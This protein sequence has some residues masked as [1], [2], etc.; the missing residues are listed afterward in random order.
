[1]AMA[2]SIPLQVAP[3]AVARVAEL[4]MQQEFEAMLEHARQTVA[5]LRSLE[6]TLYHDEYE[7]GQPRVVITAWKHGDPSEEETT[8]RDWDAWVVRAFSPDVFRWFSFD[9][10]YWDHHGR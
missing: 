5:N 6:V 3:E 4:G 10:L 1:M 7:P 2:A 9:A 8:E